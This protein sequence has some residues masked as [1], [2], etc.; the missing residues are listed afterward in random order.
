MTI[1]TTAKAKVF[2]G[3]PNATIALLAEFEAEDWTEIKEVEDL[4]EWGAEGTE[5][6]FIS[7]ADSHTRRRKGSIDSGTVALIVGRDPLD[8]GQTKARAAVEE[9]LP[10]AFKVELNDKPTPTGENTVFYFRAPVMS[11][12]N[13]F[14]TADDITKTTFSL[15]IDGAILEIPSAVVVAFLPAAGALPGATQNTAYNQTIAASGGL[16]TVSY[17]VTAGALPA[18][19]TLNA[20][21]GAISGTPTAVE[22]A[23]FTITATYTGSGEAEAAYTLAVTA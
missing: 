21:T 10:Y 23:N 13:Q 8:P 12:R 4:G 9:W 6:T 7:L 16:G 11:A 5:V 20:A 19:L 3:N 14:G 18:G 22:N 17:A 1:N 15:G 2:I